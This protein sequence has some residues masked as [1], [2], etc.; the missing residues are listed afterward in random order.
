ML[1]VKMSTS[2]IGVSSIHLLQSFINSEHS[3]WEDLKKQLVI[4]GTF[5]VGALILSVIDYLH[6]KSEHSAHNHNQT[7]GH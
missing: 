3:N 4:H 7:T 6:E 2:L 5:L 1:K